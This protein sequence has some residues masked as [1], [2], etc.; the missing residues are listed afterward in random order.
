MPLVIVDVA[1]HGQ[2]RRHKGVQGVDVGVVEEEEFGAVVLV[3]QVPIH[4]EVDDGGKRSGV[5]LLE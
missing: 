5:T 2:Q 1:N 4:P 3:R